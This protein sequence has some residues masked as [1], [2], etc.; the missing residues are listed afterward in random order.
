MFKLKP[1]GRTGI[2]Q[3]KREKRSDLQAMET[4]F[5]KI[6]SQKKEYNLIKELK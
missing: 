5:E 2:M 6:T 3:E 4:A 1:E